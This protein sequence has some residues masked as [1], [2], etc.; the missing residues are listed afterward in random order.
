M[1]WLL[2]DFPSF[3]HPIKSFKQ[4]EQIDKEKNIEADAPA[5]NYRYDATTN[6]WHMKEKETQKK[7]KRPDS[8]K[9]L[10]VNYDLMWSP[11]VV[12][13]LAS[14]LPQEIAHI[15]EW[16]RHRCV[17]EKATQPMLRLQFYDPFSHC[18][19]LGEI[20]S[21]PPFTKLQV[22]PRPTEK[23]HMY[24]MVDR[25]L[26]F[27]PGCNDADPWNLL[28]QTTV[29]GLYG[30][31]TAWCDYTGF[32]CRGGMDLYVAHNP[33]DLV[34]F[35]MDQVARSSFGWDINFS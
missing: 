5:E 21:V 26:W 17:H 29:P 7:R 13:E 25:I 14:Y 10:P 9:T 4:M 34:R 30:Y 20:K 31:Y 6:L 3:T 19:M 27:Y 1:L 11:K 18:S 22:P 2:I 23:E 33:L 12:K 16:Y 32:D 15:I 35:A 8:E 24:Q 28:F